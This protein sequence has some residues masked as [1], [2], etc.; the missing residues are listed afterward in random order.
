MK[1]S[2]VKKKYKQKAGFEHFYLKYLYIASHWLINL[3]IHIQ[4]VRYLK[5]NK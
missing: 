4:N 2:T 3:A 1:Q 5:G